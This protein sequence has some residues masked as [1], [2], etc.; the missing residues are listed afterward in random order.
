MFEGSGSAAVAKELGV[1][2]GNVATIL[3]RA[4]AALKACILE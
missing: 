1:N 4:K 2:E 3:N